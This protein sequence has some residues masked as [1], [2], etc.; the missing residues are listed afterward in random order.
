VFGGMLFSTILNLIFI[1]LYVLFKREA[2]VVPV[3]EPYPVDQVRRLTGMR[4][5]FHNHH[6]LTGRTS[7]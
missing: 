5:H 7:L 4:Y 2:K 3:A 1:P 6:R